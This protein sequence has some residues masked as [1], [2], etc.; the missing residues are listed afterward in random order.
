M[1]TMLFVLQWFL[2]NWFKVSQL[3][4]FLFYP[5]DA[6][7]P[8]VKIVTPTDLEF[9]NATLLCLVSDFYPSEVMVFW[10]HNANR[11]RSSWYTSSFPAHDT[12]SRSFFLIS[13][14]NIAQPQEDQG[15]TYSCVVQHE[16]SNA[17]VTSSIRNVFGEWT[18]TNKS[19]TLQSTPKKTQ[20]LGSHCFMSTAVEMVF[21]FR[22]RV[23]RS[24]R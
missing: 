3:S 4:Y 23:C 21:R 2:I 14:L 12:E 10:V 6:K 17:P 7:P 16:S 1:S 19:T 15:S 8:K 22:F 24:I 13:R 18:K 11:L 5:L 9:G 20:V